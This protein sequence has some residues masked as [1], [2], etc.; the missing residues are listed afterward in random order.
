MSEQFRGEW[1]VWEVV[2]VEEHDHAS[3]R[4]K[5]KVSFFMEANFGVEGNASLKINATPALQIKKDKRSIQV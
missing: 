2:K 4:K 3:E 5:E 1:R